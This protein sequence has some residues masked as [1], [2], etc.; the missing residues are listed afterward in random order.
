MPHPS[1]TPWK[2]A[3]VHVPFSWPLLC[4]EHVHLGLVPFTLQ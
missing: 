2:D 1:N 4:L 3:E